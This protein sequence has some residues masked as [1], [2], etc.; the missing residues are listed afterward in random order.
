MSMRARFA[1]VTSSLLAHDERTVLVLADISVSA[2]E[3]VQEQF[4]ARV[5]NVGIREQLMVG[6]AGGL[7][8]TGFRPI[9]HS[10]APFIVDR[11]YEQIKLDLD[12]QDRGAILV[13]IG[14][15]YDASREGRTHFA[16][17]DVALFD[18]FDGWRVHVPGHPDEVEEMLRAAAIRDDGTYIRL[19]AQSNASAHDDF[20]VIRDDGPTT[21][22]GVGVMLD[23]VVEA[24]R[25]LPVRI[26]YLHTVRPLD[27]ERLRA[28]AG[29]GDVA[30][31]EPYLEGTSVRLFSA[32]L[33]DAARRF[34]FLGVRR[35]D[36]R[37]YGTIA[38]HDRWHEL[39]VSSVRRR[40]AQF[41]GAGAVAS[42][43]R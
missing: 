13:S 20:E 34:S 14:A 17:E 22:F 16:P 41:I 26:V 35:Q 4:P 12:H 29:D 11:V 36:P 32:A 28:V 25:D 3:D 2:F 6:V 5:V 38:D 18:T 39:D 19:H 42:T 30:V 27:P 37:R 15:S 24:S 33:G 31:V 10:Y 1:S 40:L 23:R 43:A 7:A 9:V 8:M 21:V